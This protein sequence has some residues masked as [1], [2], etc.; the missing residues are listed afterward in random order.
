MAT[1]IN[2]VAGRVTA[3]KIFGQAT[4]AIAATEVQNAVAP[5]IFSWSSSA[6]ATDI[7]DN[8][9][10]AKTGLKAGVYRLSV[11]DALHRVAFMTYTVKSNKRLHIYPGQVKNVQIYGEHTGFIENVSIGG[12]DGNYTI[13]WTADSVTP[14]LDHTVRPKLY[15]AAANYVLS[16]IDGVGAN[17]NYTFVITQTDQL[18]LY[19]AA[20]KNAP[21]FGERGGSVAETLISGG[22]APYDFFWTSNLMSTSKAVV[23]LIHESD[24]TKS[25]MVPDLHK[26]IPDIYL[27]TV[28]DAWGAVV[29]HSYKI[30]EG[31]DKIYYAFG[32]SSNF[33]NNN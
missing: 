25:Y 18:S 9:L 17:A 32:S 12:G 5:L 29:Q 33:S 31:P 28:S 3:V 13:Y 19:P 7:I 30:N 1:S 23:P 15:L 11:T 22:T 27:L 26:L 20:T 16:V 10:S 24:G 8:T 6:E 21:I 14:I 2:I 4:G